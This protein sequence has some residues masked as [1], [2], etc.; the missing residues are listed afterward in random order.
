MSD[1]DQQ[2]DKKAQNSTTEASLCMITTRLSIDYYFVI[3]SKL[4]KM[5]QSKCRSI[6]SRTRT[7]ACWE[8]WSSVSTSPTTTSSSWWRTT[9][10]LLAGL[11]SGFHSIGTFL[12]FGCGSK[13]NNYGRHIH[14][15]YLLASLKMQGT[16]PKM[17][18]GNEVLLLYGI[19]PSLFQGS[20]PRKL[21]VS[22]RVGV[23]RHATSVPSFH[24]LILWLGVVCWT[25]AVVSSEKN[26]MSPHRCIHIPCCRSP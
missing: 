20:I 19:V 17:L 3:A 8:I 24:R 14:W 23:V 7:I 2:E 9:P 10:L 21:L 22:L 1:G 26:W 11:E 12:K 6:D 25:A 18:T 15:A 13:G 5:R 16:Y 4:L